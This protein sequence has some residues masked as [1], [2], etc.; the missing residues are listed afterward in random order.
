[1]TFHLLLRRGIFAIIILACL[2]AADL[3]A[4]STAESTS[5]LRGTKQLSVGIILPLSGRAATM[6]N[7]IH[8]GALLALNSL[9]PDLRARLHVYFE[10]DLSEA[11]NTVSAFRKLRIENKVE[12]VVTALSNAGNAIVPL[13]E[14]AGMP[15]IAIAVDQNISKGREQAVTIWANL[16]DLAA[17]AV[18][19]AHRRGYK[20]VAMVTTLHEGNI[21]MRRS[22]VSA[23]GSIIELPFSEEVLPTDTDFSTIISKIGAAKDLDAIVNMLHP[24][25]SGIFVKQAF[26]QGLKLP[27]FSLTNFEDLGV[28]RSAG[29][30][31]DGQWYVAAKYAPTFVERYKAHYPDASLLGAAYGND[32]ILLLAEALKSDLEISKYLRTVKGFSG[33]VETISADGNNGFRMPVAVKVVGKDGI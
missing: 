4:E 25:Q 2:C 17:E 21:A 6:G 18:A 30:A 8:N 13:S 20:K 7:A 28:R 24:M 11:R 10:D 14:E 12:V 15:L 31:L 33:A 29:N 3:T 22:L 16:D 1:M 23:A 19:E 26:K 27:Q 5:E 32:V 9:D